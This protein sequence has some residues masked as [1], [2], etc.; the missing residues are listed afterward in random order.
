MMADCLSRRWT[1]NVKPFCIHKLIGEIDSVRGFVF[2]M[3]SS[4]MLLPS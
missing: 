3:A 2:A 1:V 4:W